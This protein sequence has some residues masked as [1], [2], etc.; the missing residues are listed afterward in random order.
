MKTS[1]AVTFNLAAGLA[2]CASHGL[3]QPPSAGRPPVAAKPEAAVDVLAVVGGQP[4][5]RADVEAL[6]GSRL[7]ELRNQEYNILRQALDEKITRI[8]LEG[9]AARRKISVPELISQEIES[10]AAPVTAEEQKA[11]YEQNKAQFGTMPEAEALKNAET[12]LRQQRVRARGLE[13]VGGLRTALGVKV[14]LDAPRY[15]LSASPDDP[16]K[17]PANAPVTIVEFSDFECPYCSRVVPTLKKIEEH[18]G[19]K[20]RIVFRDLPLTQIHK[21]AAKAAEA[22][23]CAHEQGKFWEMHDKLFANQASLSVDDLKKTALALGLE[24]QAFNTCLDS[25]RHTPEW[26]ADAAEA[27]SVGVGSTPAFLVNGRLLSGAQAYDNFVKVIDEELERVAGPP[28]TAGP[29][30]K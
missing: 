5:T 17:G 19:P 8:A 6:A 30:V 20:V 7:A 21:N 14:H 12:R 10:K 13:F 16:A 3:A 1:L 25:G 26:Q 4:V 2:L 11:F 29:G 24:P 22:G 27:A 9:E 15:A 23:S 28:V 18:Y